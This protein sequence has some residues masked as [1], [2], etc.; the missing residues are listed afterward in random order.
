M[1]NNVNNTTL[2]IYPEDIDPSL[3]SEAHAADSKIVFLV[4]HCS[5]D[6]RFY[7]LHY[8]QSG[9]LNQ[10]KIDIELLQDAADSVI[11]KLKLLRV[12]HFEKSKESVFW[13]HQAML[14]STLR[15]KKN[16]QSRESCAFF[17]PSSPIPRSK[18]ATPPQSPD[19]HTDASMDLIKA[20]SSEELDG[21]VF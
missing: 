4:K 3:L 20:S 8:I 5:Y 9:K 7:I 17:S 1:F 6:N 10:T 19:E 12:I 14:N 15:H 11:Q 18:T 21:L 2:I 16:E 13:E